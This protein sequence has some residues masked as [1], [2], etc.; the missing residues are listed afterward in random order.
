MIYLRLSH[1]KVANQSQ[2][3]VSLAGFEPETD[4]IASPSRDILF[5]FVLFLFVCA[6]LQVSALACRRQIVQ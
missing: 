5:C 2:N 3:K 4:M 6:G 1:T